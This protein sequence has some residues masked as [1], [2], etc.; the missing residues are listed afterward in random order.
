[1]LERVGGP[2][3]LSGIGVNVL[4]ESRVNGD[5]FTKRPEL[6]LVNSLSFM[7]AS[8]TSQNATVS[9]PCY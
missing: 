7:R 9:E 4:V 8:V 3:I 6:S 2:E 1:V 5:F